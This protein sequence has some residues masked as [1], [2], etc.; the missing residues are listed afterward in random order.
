[1]FAGRFDAYGLC[2]YC[3]IIR[4]EWFCGL[5]C[6]IVEDGFIYVGYKTHSKTIHSVCADAWVVLYVESG[7]CDV[8]LGFLYKCYV[9]VVCVHKVFYAHK[10]FLNLH[11]Y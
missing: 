4:E 6:V 3:Y 9:N 1:M 5:C 8:E 7:V 2:F 10:V 11:L